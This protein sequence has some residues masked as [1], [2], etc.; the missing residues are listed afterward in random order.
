MI[1]IPQGAHNTWIR[2]VVRYD[3]ADDKETSIAKAVK[4]GFMVSR[5]EK[6]YDI[7]RVSVGMQTDGITPL[8]VYMKNVTYLYAGYKAND[9]DWITVDYILFQDQWF[10][11][12]NGKEIARGPVINP[13]K[14]ECIYFPFVHFCGIQGEVKTLEIRTLENR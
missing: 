14:K 4:L 10:C 12:I 1:S 13:V 2:M 7:Q 5:E 11:L 3:D 9:K 8:K 6:D